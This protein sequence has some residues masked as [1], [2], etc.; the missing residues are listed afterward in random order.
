MMSNNIMGVRL[1]QGLYIGDDAALLAD[2]FNEDYDDKHFL[3]I[4]GEAASNQNRNR[5]M[6]GPQ[7]PPNASNA[8]I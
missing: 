2:I 5:I 3:F 8:E 6:G 7:P 4:P 1:G